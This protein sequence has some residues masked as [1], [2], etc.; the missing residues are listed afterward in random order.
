MTVEERIEQLE[1]RIAEL[2]K[3]HRPAP[4]G[5]PLPTLTT[6]CPVCGMGSD[7]QPYGYVC[8]RADCPSSFR[9]S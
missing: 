7:G 3:I 8:N 2:E 9:C 4:F 5:I 6:G 1:R